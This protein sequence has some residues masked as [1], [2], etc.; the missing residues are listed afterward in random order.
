MAQR[1]KL[2]RRVDRRCLFNMKQIVNGGQTSVGE[3]MVPQKNFL[4]SQGEVGIASSQE[5]LRPY[6]DVSSSESKASSPETKFALRSSS[7]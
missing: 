6:L 7:K 1:D 5:V 4:L 3:M 2:G